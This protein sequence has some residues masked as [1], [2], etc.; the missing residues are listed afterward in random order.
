MKGT[1]LKLT[2]LSTHQFGSLSATNIDRITDGVCENRSLPERW[3]CK[4]LPPHLDGVLAVTMMDMQWM[5][6]PRK[7]GH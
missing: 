7:V 1:A 2:G 5:K 4:P 6:T 3:L